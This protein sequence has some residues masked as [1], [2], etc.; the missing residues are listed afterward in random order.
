MLPYLLEA[1]YFYLLFSERALS[2]AASGTLL[3]L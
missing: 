2:G 3:G 1:F